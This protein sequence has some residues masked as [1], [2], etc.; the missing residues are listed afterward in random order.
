MGPWTSHIWRD[1]PRHLGFLLAR[2]KFCAKVLAGRKNVLEV[3]CGDAFGISVVKQ[4][5]LSIHGIDLEP[6]VLQDARDRKNGEEQEGITLSVHDMTKA[7]MS[8]EF[9]AAYSLDVIEHIPLS[10]EPLFMEHLCASLNPHSICILGTPN[11]T[12]S[13]YASR[14]AAEG[15]INLKSAETLSKLM[16]SF[17]HH[18]LLFSMNDEVVHTGFYPMAHYLLAVGIEKKER[19]E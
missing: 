7:A 17:F 18:C 3:G 16:L 4:T 10:D 2:Y 6:L 11:I 1:D 13:A 9:D 15:H 14:F 19:H 5:V 8:E 12:A